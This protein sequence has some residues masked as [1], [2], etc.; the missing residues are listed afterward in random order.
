M[1]VAGEQSRAQ[2]SPSSASD[3]GDKRNHIISAVTQS[4]CQGSG[5][6]IYHPRGNGGDGGGCKRAP[7][8]AL[9]QNA[10]SSGLEGRQS[11]GDQ[12]LAHGPAAGFHISLPS[13]PDLGHFHVGQQQAAFSF[14]LV[15][16]LLFVLASVLSMSREGCWGGNRGEK[17][18]A[19]RDTSRASVA[20][21]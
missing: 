3:P 5:Q 10:R 17:H 16:N 8:F 9:L 4:H 12:T 15:S 21:R 7:R 18:A 19:I 20:S 11:T 6:S 13:P 14:L 2:Q 1:A